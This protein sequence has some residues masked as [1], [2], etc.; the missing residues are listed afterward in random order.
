[1]QVLIIMGHPRKLSLTSSIAESYAKGASDAGVETKMI[2]VC[3]LRFDPNVTHPTPHLQT[4]EPDI[5][6]SRDL[7]LWADHLVFVYPTW[8]GTMPA[9]LKGFIDRV[10]ILGF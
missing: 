8:W 2:Y 9:L 10:F 6:A 4:D 1:M 3:D 5:S 7:I